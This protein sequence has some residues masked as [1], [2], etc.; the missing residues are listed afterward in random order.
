MRAKYTQIS[1]HTCTIK[2]CKTQRN[3]AIKLWILM[4]RCKIVTLSR[5]AH[6]TCSKTGMLIC[7]S[8]KANVLVTLFKRLDLFFIIAQ[9]LANTLTLFVCTIRSKCTFS[10]V[11]GLLCVVH[12][13]LRLFWLAR[14]WKAMQNQMKC[15]SNFDKWL[16]S[17]MKTLP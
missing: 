1:K 12:D 5:I 16:R 13:N 10:I 15:V 8:H 2:V 3:W 9:I 11:Q 4:C 7:I 17:K 6:G 14:W